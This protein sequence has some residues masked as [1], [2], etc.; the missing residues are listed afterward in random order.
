MLTQDT[1]KFELH[2]LDSLIGPYP[3]M[4]KTY[5]ERSP[6]QNLDKI[7]SPV[8]LLQGKDDKVV[9][10]AQSEKIY[11]K[12]KEK[13]IPTKLILFDEEGHGFR[14]ASTIERCLEAEWDFYKTLLK[15]V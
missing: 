1:H 12:L 10:P 7:S 9:P 13:N 8:L 11:L 2:Y 5:D 14:K 4:K 3:Q 6:V 15:L